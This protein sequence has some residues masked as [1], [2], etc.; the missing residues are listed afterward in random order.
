MNIDDAELLCYLLHGLENEDIGRVEEALEGNPALRLRALRLRKALSP[1]QVLEDVGEPPAELHMNTLRLVAACRAQE[2][3]KVSPAP[4][5]PSPTVFPMA[6]GSWRRADFLVAASILFVLA[7]LLPPGLLYLRHRMG[8][9]NCANNLRQYHMG[10]R[11]FQEGH[12]GYMPLLDPNQ[13][14]AIAGSFPARLKEAGCWPEG[15]SIHCPN[16]FLRQ[17]GHH[18]KPLHELA[19]NGPLN[20]ADQRQLGGCYA[21]TLGYYEPTD[22]ERRLRSVHR[23]MGDEVPVMADRPPR[24]RELATWETA[25]SPN[26][27]GRGQNVLFQGGHV[28][29][30]ILRSLGQDRDIFRNNQGLTAAGVGRDDTVLGPSEATPRPV[31]EPESD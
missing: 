2:S 14:L 9:V 22:P 1:L 31:T 23:D 17:A 13:P 19:A 15:V 12:D 29:F 3:R 7:M 11:Q 8:I 25:N 5:P 10:L 4:P 28:R 21:Y 6:R 24:P 30:E 27:G 20:E 26:H 16:G 18:P